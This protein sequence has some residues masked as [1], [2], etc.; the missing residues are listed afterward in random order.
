[1]T[2]RALFGGVRGVHGDAAETLLGVGFALHA[3]AAL[4]TTAVVAPRVVDDPVP[5]A[6]RRG[7]NIG[8]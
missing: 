1:M 2:M 5:G 8:T 6:V 4:L 3:D 7:S